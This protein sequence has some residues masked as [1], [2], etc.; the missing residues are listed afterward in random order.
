MPSR[1]QWARRERR[2]A[3]S[4]LSPVVFRTQPTVIAERRAG[5]AQPSTHTK[6]RLATLKRDTSM[7]LAS[8]LHE[9]WAISFSITFGAPANFLSRRRHLRPDAQLRARPVD[10]QSLR[11]MGMPFHYAESL[12][13]GRAY[14]HIA[15][16]GHTTFSGRHGHLSAPY[17]YR[18]FIIRAI[19]RA[20]FSPAT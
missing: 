11:A 2:G 5:H 3:A 18:V 7:P 15:H 1:A 9:A 20:F 17:T 10:S 4:A 16:D 6:S 14:G 12:F 8:M 19:L 13:A